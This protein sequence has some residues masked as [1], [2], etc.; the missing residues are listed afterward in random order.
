MKRNPSQFCQWF[1]FIKF[2]SIN[3]KLKET[4]YITNKCPQQSTY[5]ASW[6]YYWLYS[7]FKPNNSHHHKLQLTSKFQQPPINYNPITQ[8]LKVSMSL[9]LLS[10][11]PSINN[12]IWSNNWKSKLKSKFKNF[13]NVF[14]LLF[15]V[16]K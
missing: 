12:T 1:L 7:P 6:F 4:H 9:K 3:N 5:H 2:Q 11:L 14:F 15:V 8:N 16:D 13:R 10:S